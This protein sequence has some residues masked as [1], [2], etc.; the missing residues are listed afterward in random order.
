MLTDAERNLK[1]IETDSE[2]VL[3]QEK[4]QIKNQAEQ[5]KG[6]K[7]AHFAQVHCVDLAAEAV[8]CLADP[9]CL[10][11]CDHTTESLSPCLWPICTRD[12]FDY[13]AVFPTTCANMANKT[14]DRTD[15]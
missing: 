11:N 15:L 14:N 5:K 6:E 13:W 2:K 8:S 7:L 3:K 4:I 1:V 10:S 12:M 9:F